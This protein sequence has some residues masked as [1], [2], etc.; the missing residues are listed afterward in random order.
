[1]ESLLDFAALL[2]TVEAVLNYFVCCMV[3]QHVAYVLMWMLFQLYPAASVW[4][5]RQAWMRRNRE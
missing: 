2:F 1:M 4:I 3:I 5:I